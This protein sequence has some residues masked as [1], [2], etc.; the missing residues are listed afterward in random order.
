MKKK[1]R[2]LIKETENDPRYKGYQKMYLASG[3]LEGYSMEEVG[4]MHISLFEDQCPIQ[5]KGNIPEEE[6]EN[7]SMVK[8]LKILW[9]Y[10]Q[11]NGP[12]KLTLKGNMP[13]D[14]I[15]AIYKIAGVIIPC[16]HC[17][18]DMTPEEGLS[19]IPVM[20]AVGISQCF[21]QTFVKNNYLHLADSKPEFISGNAS[22][23]KYSFL[24]FV[25]GLNWQCLDGFGNSEIGPFEM[26]FMLML[27]SKFGN[28]FRSQHFY[29]DKYFKTFPHLIDCIKTMPHM[30][31]N[32]DDKFLLDIAS[33]CYN[34]RV[35]G[36]F[37][38]GFGLIEIKE[39]ENEPYDVLIKKS[40]LF[41]KLITVI[42]P[43]GKE[44]LVN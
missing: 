28:E 11:D 37:L 32:A 19:V 42:A 27:L 20:S 40:E 39:M 7:I 24:A 41:D 17:G 14:V 29:S 10:L 22:L 23:Y 6:F 31:K 2:D 30:K 8:I 3:N 16:P 33:I 12:V 36:R 4:F 5:F 35:F 38:E 1:Y 9:Q 26:G 21:N 34:S 44:D 13:D 15:N 25:F 18:D 43:I